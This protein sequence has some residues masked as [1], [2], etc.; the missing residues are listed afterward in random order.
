MGEHDYRNVIAGL[1]VDRHDT[2]WVFNQAGTI[3]AIDSS[4]DQEV[5][6]VPGVLPPNGGAY[7]FAFDAQDRVWFGT[8]NGLAMIDYRGT[9][10]DPS[11][12]SFA[13]FTTSTN[14]QSVAIDPDG[15]PWIATSQGGGVLINGS[16][17]MYTTAT[18]GILSNTVSRVRIDTWG[19]VWFLT[20]KGISLFDPHRQRWSQPDNNRGLIP[21]L[22][23]RNAFYTW[24]QL[25]ENRRTALIG[26]LAGL[27]KFTFSETPE[28]T[29]RAVRIYPNPFVRGSHAEILFDSLPS[30][31]TQIQV[32]TLAGEL[33]AES[34]T[35][36]SAPFYLDQIYHK[37]R[38]TPGNVASG[39]YLAVVLTAN[40]RQVYRLAIVQ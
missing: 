6:A 24:L 10:H 5:F 4:D 14:V 33:V 29:L 12:D 13:F 2:K 30:S 19:N 32:F 37:A 39:L 7:D 25:D 1:G 36:P 23:Q 40:D 11:D 31:R 9:L 15:R 26:T 35:D 17:T 16:F 28:S 21:N 34:G 38:W 8:M 22:S 3:I 27:S 20:D 18:P